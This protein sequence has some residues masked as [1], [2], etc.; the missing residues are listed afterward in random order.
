MK[1]RYTKTSL[2]TLRK[3]QPKKALAIIEGMKAVAEN[4]FA[5]DNSIAALQ[6]VENGYRKRFGDWRVLYTIDIDV[7]V[8]AVFKISPRGGAYKK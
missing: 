5:K 4:P 7:E 6:G 1:T 8:L 2:K 3:M